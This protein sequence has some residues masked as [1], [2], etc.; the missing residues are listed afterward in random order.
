LT[1]LFTQF[2]EE[3]WLRGTGSPEYYGYTPEWGRID[4]VTRVKLQGLMDRIEQ[5]RGRT[6]DS[7]H[8]ANLAWF[9]ADLRFTLLL[10][11]VGRKLEP[12]YALRKQLAAG[13]P[14]DPQ[15][16]GSDLR[17]A[18]KDLDEAPLEELFR[19]YASRVR[20]RGELGV[21]SSLNQKLFNEYN[22][23]RNFLSRTSSGR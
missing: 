3:G 7:L 17:A 1:A 11:V 2:D 18:R 20:S 4:P 10:D 13:E 9:A 6:T 22:D 19:V 8:R 14:V 12:A 15:R 5:V 23:L 16:M 21:L